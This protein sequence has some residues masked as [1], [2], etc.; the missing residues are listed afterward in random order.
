MTSDST[1]KPTARQPAEASHIQRLRM[2]VILLSFAVGAMLM[3]IKF[4]TYSLTLSTAVLSDA[5]ESIINVVAAAFASVSV[6]LAAKPPDREHPYGHGKIEYF[7][8]GFEGALIIIAASGIFYSGIHQIMTPHPLPRLQ[9]GIGI[10]AGA[11]I[12]NLLL[13]ICL[14]R[15]GR[16][17]QS[18]T[19]EAD[20]RHIITDVYTSGAVVA[21]MVLVNWTGWDRLDGIVACMVGINILVTGGRLIRQSFARLMDASDPILLD[22]IA[23]CLQSHRRPQWIDI[24]KLR[25]WQAGLQIHIDLH[26][27]LPRDFSME[28]SHD[29][30]KD[31]EVLLLRYFDGRANALVHIDPCYESLCPVC[32][33]Q[34]CRWRSHSMGPQAAWD[35]HHVSRLQTSDYT[36]LDDESG[37]YLTPSQHLDNSGDDK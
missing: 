34:D 36:G 8:A 30:A 19:L 15:V 6:W 13:G 22:R 31:V 29:E 18:I 7:S 33:G 35:R 28:Q 10:L 3:G 2:R 25:A 14:L 37:P 17:T 16:R 11:T 12:A 1:E 24:H 32:R 4:L 9:E 21:G 26:L 20:G 27:V 5:L 23:T